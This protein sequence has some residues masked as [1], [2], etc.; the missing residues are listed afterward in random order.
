[1]PVSYPL[2]WAIVATIYLRSHFFANCSCTDAK[3]GFLFTAF[4]G[5]TTGNNNF[6]GNCG[7]VTGGVSNPGLMAIYYGPANG[8]KGK[9]TKAQWPA[10]STMSGTA[11]QQQEQAGV[12]IRDV[13]YSI[14]LKA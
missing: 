10:F 4:P 14:L 12:I 5:D 2:A 13:S 9:I 6:L 1:M 7:E 3:S 8:W 11:A